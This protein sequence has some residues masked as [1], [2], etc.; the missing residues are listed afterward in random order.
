MWR[1]KVSQLVNTDC[2]KGESG[3][4]SSPKGTPNVAYH[5][6]CAMGTTTHFIAYLLGSKRPSPF[7]VSGLSLIHISEPTRP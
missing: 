5:I 2:K 3:A 1:C 4:N 7:K 6:A